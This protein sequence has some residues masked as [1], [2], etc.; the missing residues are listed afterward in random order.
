MF[1]PKPD[2]FYIQA[3]SIF[4]CHFSSRNVRFQIII[5]FLPIYHASLPKSEIPAFHSLFSRLA[6]A[7]A[8]KE[9]TWTPEALLK[10]LEQMPICFQ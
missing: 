10:I 2:K 4:P 7:A 1:S 8:A 9:T 3:G 5:V 6:R